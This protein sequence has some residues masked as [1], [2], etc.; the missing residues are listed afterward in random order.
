MREGPRFGRQT[1]R[2]SGEPLPDLNFRLVVA[3]THGQK[4]AICGSE[5]SAGRRGDRS[6]LQ[7]PCLLPSCRC[8]SV[9]IYAND[10]VHQPVPLEVCGLLILSCIENII[11]AYIAS[12]T[13]IRIHMAYILLMHAIK[14][15]VI[16]S[17][18]LYLTP[19]WNWISQC[20][21]G[22]G[23]RWTFGRWDILQSYWT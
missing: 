15:A 17:W 7:P 5:F 12:G 4:L 16:A 6:M 22:C 14:H 19:V 13:R 3:I 20:L 11:N 21:F 9:H 8:G 23:W 18:T 2:G 1:F 10:A